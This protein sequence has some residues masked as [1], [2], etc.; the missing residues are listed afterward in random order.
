MAIRETDVLCGHIR[1]IAAGNPAVTAFKGIPYAEAPTGNNRWRPPI[2]KKPWSGTFDAVRF[3]NICPQVIPQPGTFYHKEFFSY[4][5]LE[6]HHEDCLQLNIWT[7]ADS[8]SDNLPVLVFIHG[9]GFQTNYSFAPQFDGEL[10]AAQGIVVVTINYRLGLFGFL[11]HP[12]L[13]DESPR[14]K[15]RRNLNETNI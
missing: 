4:Q 1:G 8:K 11:A 10:M 9:G 7:P 15:G 6:T 5:H 14:M 2:P 13:R 12:D 3:G